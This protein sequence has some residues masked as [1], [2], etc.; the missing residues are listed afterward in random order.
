MTLAVEG[1]R[2]ALPPGVDLAAF[3]IVQEALTNVRK[4]AGAGAPVDVALRYGGGRLEIVVEDRGGSGDGV[5]QNGNGNGNGNGYGLAGMRERV[6][7]YG[8]ALDVGHGEGGFRV[9]ASLPVAEAAVA[10]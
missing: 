2:V 10:R 4:H 3:R 9:R 5:P 8:G 7:L 6:A 1:E